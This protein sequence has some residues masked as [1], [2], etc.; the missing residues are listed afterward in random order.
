MQ[1]AV[2]YISHELT[3]DMSIVF[4]SKFV[5]ASS[6]AVGVTSHLT[7]DIPVMAHHVALFF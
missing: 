4:L 2:N 1:T 5:A 3:A 6:I 7:A